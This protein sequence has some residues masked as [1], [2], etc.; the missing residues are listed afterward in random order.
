MRIL[1]PF[2]VELHDLPKF[3]AEVHGRFERR[4]YDPEVIKLGGESAPP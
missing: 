3:Q 4:L 2:A 1:A